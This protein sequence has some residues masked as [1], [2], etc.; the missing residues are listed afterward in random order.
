MICKV[1][2]SILVHYAVQLFWDERKEYFE[3]K[4]IDYII[5]ITLITL[6]KENL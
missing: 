4:P 3:N 2:Q 6:W 5:I 1:L